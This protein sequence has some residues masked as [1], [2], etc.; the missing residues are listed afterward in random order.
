[1]LSCPPY[2]SLD[3]R[4]ATWNLWILWIFFE[5]LPV[6]K[7]QSLRERI[8]MKMFQFLFFEDFLMCDS[9]C[10]KPTCLHRRSCNHL[11]SNK[12]TDGNFCFHPIGWKLFLSLHDI[13]PVCTKDFFR[14]SKW[15]WLFRCSPITPRYF[16]DDFLEILFLSQ[17][18]ED[19]PTYCSLWSK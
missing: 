1:M 18:L 8:L 17:T 7:M 16:K 13:R 2:K 5:N 15:M 9:Q 6:L 3:A 12:R 11:P 14:L 10:N 4:T 19:Q